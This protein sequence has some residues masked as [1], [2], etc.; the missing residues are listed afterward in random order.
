[1]A[2]KS[3][4]ERRVENEAERAIK[5]QNEGN[6]TSAANIYRRLLQIEEHNSNIWHLLGVTRHLQGYSG[7]GAKFIS[8]AI[9][10][11]KGN[12]VALY[13]QNLVEVCRNA[14]DLQCAYD[15][16]LLTWDNCSQFGSH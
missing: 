2:S 10:L 4:I 5:L 9:N 16:L 15:S 8:H 14:G 1:M 6:F 3:L 12:F 7:T 13:H 11:E